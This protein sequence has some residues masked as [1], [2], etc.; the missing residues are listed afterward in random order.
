MADPGQTLAATQQRLTDLNEQLLGQQTLEG[1]RDDDIDRLLVT[2]HKATNLNFGCVDWKAPHCVVILNSTYRCSPR[3][4]AYGE[5]PIWEWHTELRHTGKEEFLIFEIRNVSLNMG[6]AYMPLDVLRQH[7]VLSKALPLMYNG[8]TAGIDIQ[9]A[10]GSELIPAVGEKQEIF[11]TVRCNYATSQISNFGSLQDEQLLRARVARI[12]RDV[13][14][15]RVTI[16]SFSID[17]TNNETEKPAD[18]YVPYVKICVG[19]EQ[20]KKTVT[21]FRPHYTEAEEFVFHDK[22]KCDYGGFARGRN[23]RYEG[24]PVAPPTGS[25]ARQGYRK[26]VAGD[27]KVIFRDARFVFWYSGQDDLDLNVNQDLILGTDD[28]LVSACVHFEDLFLRAFAQDE[29]SDGY[30]GTGILTAPLKAIDMDIISKDEGLVVGEISF[31]V[32]F[33]NDP[34]ANPSVFENLWRRSRMMRDRATTRHRD[35]LAAIDSAISTRSLPEMLQGVNQEVCR[36]LADLVINAAIFNHRRLVVHEDDGQLMQERIAQSVQEIAAALSLSRAHVES[37]DRAVRATVAP[38]PLKGSAEIYRAKCADTNLHP[39]RP[40]VGLVHALASSRSQYGAMLHSAFELA[41]EL[42][43]EAGG[44]GTLKFDGR[45]AYG[46]IERF[47]TMALP[48]V[49]EYKRIH[50]F[51][52]TNDMIYKNSRDI[53]PEE[54]VIDHEEKQKQIKAGKAAVASFFPSIDPSKLSGGVAHPGDLITLRKDSTLTLMAGSATMGVFAGFAGGL[55]VSATAKMIHN[56]DHDYFC[57]PKY[58][59]GL[60]FNKMVCDIMQNS[61]ADEIIAN[62]LATRKGFVTFFWIYFLMFFSGTYF[63][64]Q[65]R[66]A[67]VKELTLEPTGTA[68]SRHS[69]VCISGFLHSRV[70]IFRPWEVDG[71]CPWT[72]GQPYVLR[73]ETDLLLRLGETFQG[74]ITKAANDTATVAFYLASLTNPVS[75]VQNVLTTVQEEFDDVFDVTMKRA[76]EVGKYL[77][78]GL[79]ASALTEADQRAREQADPEMEDEE[80]ELSVQVDSSPRPVSLVGFSFGAAVIIGCLNE[81]RRISNS[82]DPRAPIAANLVCDVVIIGCPIGCTT[83]QW[84]DYRQLVTGRFVNGYLRSD[85]V[86]VARQIR[87]GCTNLFAGCNSLH[88]VPGIE[89]KALDEFCTMHVNYLNQMPAILAD[90]FSGDM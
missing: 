7:G 18:Y 46:L 12:R 62:W 55:G 30:G 80:A 13:A 31:E 41:A 23:D 78:N 90:I 5:N 72:Y 84:T 17:M 69:V 52:L 19:R 39:V 38:I 88:K 24:P 82:V 3:G 68:R 89:N 4:L 74:S 79:L 29:E 57:N 48:P 56:I 27:L 45:K 64:L 28:T 1:T 73:W 87:Y 21:A 43:G 76:F 10:D 6:V 49:P 33:L 65:Y 81:L 54:D 83:Q 16:H 25:L 2:V 77:A 20:H 51:C 58:Q 61:S 47:I 44:V 63:R 15:V 36:T 40:F 26:T 70:D 86:L 11:V 42:I 8:R 34:V 35:A 37:L 85:K 60:G 66:F 71:K 14:Q 32:E 75:F 59:T 9:N 67:R 53:D 22:R 50:P